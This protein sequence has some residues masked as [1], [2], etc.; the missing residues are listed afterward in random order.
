MVGGEP[1]E[2][3]L[4]RGDADVWRGAIAPALRERGVLDRLQT[5][6]L[7]GRH[8]Y[9][10]RFDHAWQNGRWHVA[11]AISLDLVDGQDILRKAAE[12]TGRVRSVDPVRQKT[13]VLLVVG[14]PQSQ[15]RENVREAASEGL[16]ILREQLA[17]EKIAEVLVEE[18]AP[19]LADRI[20]ADLA[21]E[22]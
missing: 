9:E 2:R 20:A 5:H 16:G 21:H 12:W 22:N 18:D 8:L 11:R 3:R 15:S 4:S 7:R 14:L 6:V 10:E 17:D 13:T 1:G 19:K